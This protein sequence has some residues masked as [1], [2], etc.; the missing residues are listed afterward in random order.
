MASKPLSGY[1]LTDVGERG[2]DPFKVDVHYVAVSTAR[3]SKMMDFTEPMT[4]DVTSTQ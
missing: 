2:I 4:R 1:R 3:K